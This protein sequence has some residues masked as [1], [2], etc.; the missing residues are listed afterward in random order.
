VDTKGAFEELASTI[1]AL[2][3]AEGRWNIDKTHHELSIHTIVSNDPRRSRNGGEYDFYT[4]FAVVGD[5]VLVYEE[6]SCELR[7]RGMG[8]DAGYVIPAIVGLDGLRR[9]A[10]LVGLRAA[11]KQFLK[12]GI[13][14][15]DLKAAIEAAS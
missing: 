11:C 4:C 1:E 5:G 12:R 7:I 9:I 6:T 2:L 15:A 8:R 14:F 10:A 13:G 3:P